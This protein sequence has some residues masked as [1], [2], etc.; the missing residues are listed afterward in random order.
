[1]FNNND[2]YNYTIPPCLAPGHYLVRHELIALHC[3]QPPPLQQPTPPKKE[4]RKTPTNPN[5]PQRPG[6]QAKHNSTPPATS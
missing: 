1:M 2:G 3:K 5:N 4:K 6:P